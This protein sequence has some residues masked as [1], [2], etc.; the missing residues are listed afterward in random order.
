MA[1]PAVCAP[2]NHLRSVSLGRALTASVAMTPL[3]SSAAAAAAKVTV[4][5]QAW[6][7]WLNGAL[8]MQVYL[9]MVEGECSH[10]LRLRKVQVAPSPLST[11]VVTVSEQGEESRW[12]SRRRLSW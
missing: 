2:G 8:Q 12:R 6:V 3:R 10:S 11:A 9:K 1:R 7:V 4:S 5:A